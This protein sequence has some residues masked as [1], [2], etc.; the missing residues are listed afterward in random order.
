MKDCCLVNRASSY[1]S[2]FLKAPNLAFPSFPRLFF[3]LNHYSGNSYQNC[4]KPVP[5]RSPGLLVW[6]GFVS[7]LVLFC[8]TSSQDTSDT[9]SFNV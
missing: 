9:H 3:F 6:A 1:V 7:D 4:T 2:W 5:L 8:L